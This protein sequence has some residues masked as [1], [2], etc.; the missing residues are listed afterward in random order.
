L[1]AEALAT[2]GVAKTPAHK[3][4]DTSTMAQARARRLEGVI[5]ALIAIALGAEGSQVGSPVNIGLPK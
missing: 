5:V 3:A 4:T 1:P 2:A